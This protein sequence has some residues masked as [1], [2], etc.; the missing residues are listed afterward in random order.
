MYKSELGC[1]KGETFGLFLLPEL[2]KE[3]TAA[4]SSSMMFYAGMEN[5]KG[6]G[7]SKKEND[8]FLHCVR[9]CM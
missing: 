5:E 7:E 4:M 9:T 8:V 1:V 6:Q 3:G 2:Q